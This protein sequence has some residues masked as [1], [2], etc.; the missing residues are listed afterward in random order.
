MTQ[1]LDE[2]QFRR[3]IYEKYKEHFDHLYRLHQ[4]AEQAMGEFKSHAATAYEVSL[5]LIFARAFKSFDS[6]RRLCEV[7]LCEDAGV[8]LRSFLNLLVVTRWISLDPKKRAAKYLAWYWVDMHASAQQFKD[9]IPPEWMPVI[10][11]NYARVKK[12]FEY[13]DAKGK[14]RLAKKWYEPEA[15][16]IFELF[17]QVDMKKHYEEGYAP[18]SGIEHTDTTA[19]FGMLVPMGKGGEK[20]R[21]EVQSDMFV[22]HY[23]RNAFQYFAEIFRIVNGALPLA[24]AKQL[25]EI[26]AA[27]I[28]FFRND[29]QARGIQP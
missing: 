18:L 6:I 15:H 5:W 12:Q 14:T 22:P 13:K 20:G 1:P 17:V 19:F 21:L 28:D 29:M 9:R 26:V 3:S 4:F 25:E 11:K 7:A 16:T 24:D 27:G 23:L 10:Q 2:A 8:I